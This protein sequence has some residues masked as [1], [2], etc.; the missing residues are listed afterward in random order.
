MKIIAHRGA[1]GD[2]PENTLLAFEQAIIQKCDGIEFDIQYHH[3]KKLVILHDTYV[4]KTTNGKGHFNHYSLKDLLALDAGRGESIPTLEQAL[5]FINGR[6]MVNIEVKSAVTDQENMQ[7]II[8]VLQQNIYHA[9]K[10]HHF[11]LEQFVVSSFNHHIILAVKTSIPKIKTAALIASCPIKYTQFAQSLKVSN[12]NPAIDTVNPE[13]IIDAHQRGFKVWVY[14]VDNEADIKYCHR[15]GVD[16]IFTN[17]PKN[18]RNYLN[19][20]IS[21]EDSNLTFP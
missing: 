13:F 20:L 18:S 7:E 17:Y 15:I 2:Y 11:T 8:L 3:S 12:V 16:G 14:T 10:L 6:C 5:S 19:R 4:D 9:V 21:D 1:S